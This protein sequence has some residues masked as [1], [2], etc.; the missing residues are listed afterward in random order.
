VTLRLF[1]VALLVGA[2]AILGAQVP[3][4]PRV[5]PPRPTAE[6]ARA[7]TPDSL[8]QPGDSA[9]ADSVRPPLV[10]WAEPDSAMRELLERPG[11]TSTRYQGETVTFDAGNRAINLVGE[12]AVGRDQT[13]LV[14]DTVI[15]NDSTQ[16]VRALGDTVV[17]RDPARGPDDLTSS[18]HIVYNIGQRRGQVSN[19]R[20]AVESGEKWFVGGERAAFRTDT[21]AGANAAFYARGG[22]VTSCSDSVPHYHF[23][24][25]EL[26]L[27]RNRIL[28]SRPA[29]LYIYDVPV[30]WLPFVFQDLREGRRSGILTP[31]FG[32]AE[33]FRNSP[34]YRRT[35]DNLGYYFAL[36]DYADA[37]AS[38]DWLSSARP[39]DENDN[40]GFLRYNG[41]LRYR[42]LDRFLSGRLATSYLRQRDGMRNLA[43]SWGH[44][45][46]FSQT[47][48]LTADVNYVTSTQIQRQTSY[49]PYQVLATIQSRLNYQQQFGPASFSVG[50]SRK[51]YPGRD[52]VDQD[53][54]NLNVSTRPINVGTWL[55]WTPTFSANNTVSLNNDQ[56]GQRLFR[57][58]PAANPLTPGALDS[59]LVKQN[60][61]RTTMSFNT[62]LRIFGFN[63][64]NS[65]SLNDN[66][67]DFPANRLVEEL[68]P[69]A[70][71]S[72]DTV[73][74]NRVFERTYLTSIDWQTGVD[75]PG[76]FQGTWNVTPSVQIVNVDPSAFWLRS[77]RTGGRYISQSKRLQ[78]G[79][80]AAPT[81][82]GL[83]P[84]FGPV[85]R[86]RHSLNP[87]LSYSYAPK[88]DVND[89]FLSA[90]GRTRRDYI[91]NI[92]QSSVSLSLS[93]NVEAKLRSGADTATDGGRK[94]K[95]LSINSDPITYDFVRFAELR[96][97]SANPDRLSRFSGLA[98]DRFGY[99]LTSDLLPGF[100]FQSG[101]SLFQGSPASDTAVFKPYRES[102]SASFSLNRGSGIFAAFARVFGRAVPLET[103]GDVEVATP[104]AGDALGRQVAAL[105]VAGSASRN[106]QFEVPSGQG[107]Q[108]SFTLSSNR[109]RPVRGGI[110]IDAADRCRNVPNL[111]P[112]DVERCVANPAD[113]ADLIG[114]P[115][116]T[117]NT[118]FNQ[119]TLGAPIYRTPAVTT[120]QSQTSF[121]ITPKWAAQWSTTYDVRR[122]EFAS[123]IVTLQRELHDWRAI[124]SFT[125]SPNGAFA[126][127]FFIA[128]KA[129]PDLKFNYDRRSYGR[130]GQ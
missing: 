14:G 110:Q 31:R 109:Q 94:I 5:P 88:G 8:R 74:T 92:A 78:Y 124:F 100:S 42:W 64:R 22:S 45:Q 105:P 89:E 19:V 43:L 119:T 20:T 73:Q 61:R 99:R 55:T 38:V 24:S 57:Y 86:F 23:E 36:S 40:P 103:P 37:E 6:P 39:R 101:Y 85:S 56:T 112:F 35:F 91:G 62:P 87:S 111:N 79:I 65:F 18:G 77:E 12:A 48:R 13:V 50:G 93:Q 26:K 83:F 75:L 67:D 130:Q 76:L 16:I 10:E 49:N 90:L 102:V 129:Q 11:Y 72:V 128:L 15:Y 96:R 21:A 59:V 30:M 108:S 4:K 41:E 120:L 115:L 118:S 95:V 54:P 44:Q 58:S 122:N 126:F 70:D 80:S 82:F 69:N 3:T 106:A 63:W 52:Q 98:S 121:N 116:G 97:R 28:V 104:E 125:Q 66:E 84:G 9:Q 46:D 17:L 32:I 2:P 51:Q 33:L 34:S 107:F 25:Q 68:R 81:F 113:Y 53:L 60:Q 7:A 127:T 1:A 117:D 114:L 123:H 47:S 27:V 29:V 71:G